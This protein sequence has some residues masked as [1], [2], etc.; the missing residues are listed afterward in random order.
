MYILT[1]ITF[2]YSSLVCAHTKGLLNLRRF[3]KPYEKQTKKEKGY[4]VDVAEA[5]P[6]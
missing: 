2:S 5:L 3:N 4:I 6:T 1:G